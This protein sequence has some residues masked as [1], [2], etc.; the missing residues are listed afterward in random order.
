MTF[1]FENP[2][3]RTMRRY[4]CVYF[5]PYSYNNSYHVARINIY[6]VEPDGFI[7]EF[8]DVFFFRQIF[9]FSVTLHYVLS[10]TL[11]TAVIQR[12]AYKRKITIITNGPQWNSFEIYIE[13]FEIDY[14]R[15]AIRLYRT[16][17]LLRDGKVAQDSGTLDL[18]VSKSGPMRFFRPSDNDVIKRKKVI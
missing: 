18:E 10:T 11:I 12:D 16:L 4:T 8:S 5:T 13:I 7:I 9:F 17:R 15:F 3:Q 6:R 14:F 2:P 1:F